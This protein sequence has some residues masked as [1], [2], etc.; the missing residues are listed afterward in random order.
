MRI[1]S[2][3]VRISKEGFIGVIWT[4]D[5]SGRSTE[6]NSYPESRYTEAW[7]WVEHQTRVFQRKYSVI[8]DKMVIHQVTELVET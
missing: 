2:R 1:K 6:W 7:S 4:E 5:S 3:T 8:S